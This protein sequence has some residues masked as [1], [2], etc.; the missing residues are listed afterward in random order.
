M[1]A[2]PE[3][4]STQHHENSTGDS[5]SMC[6]DRE[7][8]EAIKDEEE[9]GLNFCLEFGLLFP[10]K[11]SLFPVK[12][13]PSVLGEGCLNEDDDFKLE[14]TCLASPTYSNGS[15][16]AAGGEVELRRKIRP[17][18]RRRRSTSVPDLGG[19]ILVPPFGS[20]YVLD[21]TM[22]QYSTSSTPSPRHN[23]HHQS[24]HCVIERENTL[25]H[26][27]C[28]GDYANDGNRSRASGNVA[29]SSNYLTTSSSANLLDLNSVTENRR[30]SSNPIL[31]G[32]KSLP[33]IARLHEEER[34]EENDGKFKTGSLSTLPSSYGTTKP[35]TPS[36]S[37]SHM[38]SIGD[39]MNDPRYRGHKI[40]PT[41]SEVIAEKV[42]LATVTKPKKQF[43]ER[44]SF[45]SG[46]TTDSSFIM[47]SFGMLYS[48]SSPGSHCCGTNSIP[49][50]NIYPVD[51]V[52]DASSPEQ[53]QP[54]PTLRSGGS[55]VRSLN[56]LVVVNE[57]NGMI[58][59]SGP[60]TPSRHLSRSRSGSFTGSEAS[61]NS[62]RI[63]SRS[64]SPVQTVPASS[65]CC[66]LS[67]R[68]SPLPTSPPYQSPCPDAVISRHCFSAS[69]NSLKCPSFRGSTGGGSSTR[70]ST[71][72]FGGRESPTCPGEL[73]LPHETENV[74]GEDTTDFPAIEPQLRVRKPGIVGMTFSSGNIGGA[75]LSEIN[76]PEISTSCRLNEEAA[77]INGSDSLSQK[78]NHYHQ[79]PSEK[80]VCVRKWSGESRRVVVA[81]TGTLPG[82]RC[83]SQGHPEDTDKCADLHVVLP[84]IERTKRL[85]RLIEH[86]QHL[87]LQYALNMNFLVCYAYEN[88]HGVHLFS[89]R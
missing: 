70:G 23:H 47:D 10:L 28:S 22:F 27:S 46:T 83:T 49:M 71:S 39:W 86:R 66:G 32:A 57:N 72:S 30:E 13:S 48:P 9:T 7:G 75:M 40:G 21:N 34:I 84:T 82:S 64:E 26:K 4:K 52:F 29:V 37:G 55:S 88:V 68:G 69:N 89:F 87:Q 6:N 79:Q 60:P 67:R 2:I 17:S 5:S 80:L 65:S 8:T 14:S 35:L 74:F 54:E 20:G 63:H 1:S 19:V 73:K 59:F 78:S 43:L 44:N 77:S 15:C 33:R 41:N 81:A 11:V 85:S 50:F 56:R 12:S 61:C 62:S 31:V 24:P 36:P 58:F 76:S 16:E 18:F 25:S 53:D 51:G 3:E 45:Q 42:P 38:G